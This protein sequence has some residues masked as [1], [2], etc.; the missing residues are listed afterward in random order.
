MRNSIRMCARKLCRWQ[1]QQVECHPNLFVFRCIHKLNGRIDSRHSTRHA[2]TERG[3]DA[4]QRHQH[5][6]TNKSLL[7]R[8]LCDN[9]CRLHATM[10]SMTLRSPLCVLSFVCTSPERMARMAQVI[11]RKIMEVNAQNSQLASTQCLMLI[12]YLHTI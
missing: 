6:R 4:R 7:S 2:Q 11:Y 10:T 12:A 8:C 9:V 3:R 5:I 1:R